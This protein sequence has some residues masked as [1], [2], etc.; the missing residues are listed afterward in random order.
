M[1]S[2]YL[3]LMA[4]CCCIKGVSA[5]AFAIACPDLSGGDKNNKPIADLWI[6]GLRK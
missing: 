5:V 3:A 4:L 2:G 1:A 6:K